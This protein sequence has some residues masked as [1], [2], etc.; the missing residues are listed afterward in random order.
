M[1]ILTEVQEQE[2]LK[3][4]TNDLPALGRWIGKGEGISYWDIGR[5]GALEEGNQT[6]AEATGKAH[7]ARTTCPLPCE[8]GQSLH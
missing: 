5:A 3:L 7:A 6:A 8:C 2:K 1:E 4:G